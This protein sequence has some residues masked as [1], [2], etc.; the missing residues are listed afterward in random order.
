MRV[1]GEW[2]VGRG[3]IIV[4]ICDCDGRVSLLDAA[5]LLVRILVSKRGV[6]RMLV[7]VD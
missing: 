2:G 7:E 6:L 3:C 4:R 5:V 1:R